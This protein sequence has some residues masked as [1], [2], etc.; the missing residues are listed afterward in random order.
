MKV[1]ERIQRKKCYILV[2]YYEFCSFIFSV[3]YISNDE[4]DLNIKQGDRVVWCPDE[5]P[6]SSGTVCWNCRISDNVRLHLVSLFYSNSYYIHTSSPSVNVDCLFF[7]FY[8][9]KQ[10]M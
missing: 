10:Y 9:G 3:D 7:S 4:I 5:Q 6:P 8:L 1:K 2:D